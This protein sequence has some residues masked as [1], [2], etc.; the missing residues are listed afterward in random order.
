M[1]RRMITGVNELVPLMRVRG[2]FVTGNVVVQPELCCQL[3]LAAV[4]E[5]NAVRVTRE[6]A[7]EPS[8]ILIEV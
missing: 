8:Y 5:V 1:A 6:G 7:Q 2:V 4:L 3:E